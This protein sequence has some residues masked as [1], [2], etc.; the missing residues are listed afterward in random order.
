MSELTIMEVPISEVLN[1]WQMLKKVPLV[2]ATHERIMGCCLKG[3]CAMLAFVEDNTSVGFL[4]YSRQEPAVFFIEALFLPKNVNN[5]MPL[6]LDFIRS[7]GF[8]LVRALSNHNPEIMKNVLS[9]ATQLR[10]SYFYDG[11]I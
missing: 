5:F 10:T 11:D 8:K 4:I 6:A 2:L 1:F 9:G 7:R 3:E